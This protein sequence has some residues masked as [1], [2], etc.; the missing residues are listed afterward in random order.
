MYVHKLG[1]QFKMVGNVVIGHKAKIEFAG[2][3]VFDFLY[4]NSVYKQSKYPFISF[5]VNL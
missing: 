1:Q 4:G 2:N 5:F 3:K